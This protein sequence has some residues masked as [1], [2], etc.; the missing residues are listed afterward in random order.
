[1]KTFYQNIKTSQG[2]GREREGEGG[3]E[4]QM[5]VVSSLLMNGEGTM[6][7]QMVFVEDEGIIITIPISR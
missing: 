4:R 5:L 6:Q 7:T 3:R 1:M 2:G